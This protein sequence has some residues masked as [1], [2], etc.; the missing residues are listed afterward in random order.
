[1]A[2][3][4]VNIRSLLVTAGIGAAG[5]TNDWAI[6]IG[7]LINNP[8]NI[9]IVTSSGGIAPNP[10]WL[11][12]YPS[13][14]V[15]I[16]GK[17]YVTA[18]GKAQNVKDTL[19]GISNQTVNGDILAAVNMIGDITPLGFD[20]SNRITFAVNFSIIMHPASGTNRDSL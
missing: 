17:D 7:K 15:L 9:I 12:D 3:L 6:H 4:E 16:R 13:V 8:D 20:E 14:Q 1:M 19:L 11:V 2:I 10:K 18:K 5:G